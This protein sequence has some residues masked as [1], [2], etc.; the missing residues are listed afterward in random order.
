MEKRSWLR[1]TASWLWSY[2]RAVA[3]R[4]GDFMVSYPLAALV[5]VVLGG[6]SIL[7]AMTGR[8]LPIGGIMH[9]LFGKKEK[10]GPS[11]RN[12]VAEERTDE[13]G[14]I[15]PPGKP[16]SEGFVQV[17]ATETVEE[18]GPFDDD[19]KIVVVSPEG[20]KQE[21]PLPDGVA[22]K[23]VAEVV[24]IDPKVVEVGN[25]DRG[26]DTTGLRDALTRRRR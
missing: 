19:D 6:A 11:P 10:S 4:V 7:V 8:V 15:I 22:N 9:K 18:P 23:D 5:L 2:V 3:K 24:V 17:P 25:H 13:S 1:E 14:K 21:L 16:D 12:E 26:T 20:D